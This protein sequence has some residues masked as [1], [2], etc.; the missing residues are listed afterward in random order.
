MTA[1]GN[2]FWKKIFIII[3]VFNKKPQFLPLSFPHS[4]HTHSHTG[5]F[6]MSG[7][8][9]VVACLVREN[10]EFNK[11]TFKLSLIIILTNLTHQRRY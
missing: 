2:N 11:L 7:N 8:S 5:D 6:Q 9:R 10:L 1:L 3:D 4:M